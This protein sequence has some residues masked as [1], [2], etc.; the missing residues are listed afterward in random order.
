MEIGE[1]EA[2]GCER[3]N[4]P[5]DGARKMFDNKSE[6]VSVEVLVMVSD[7]A[8]V[9]GKGMVGFSEVEEARDGG[10]WNVACDATKGQ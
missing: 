9:E 1:F 7:V 2:P 6:G 8:C 5:C 4:P 3:T 10:N